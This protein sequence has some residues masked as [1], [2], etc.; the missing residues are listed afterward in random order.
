MKSILF[1]HGRTHRILHSIDYTL[2]VFIDKDITCH[3]DFAID[4]VNQD[5][6]SLSLNNFDEAVMV[7]CSNMVLL[8]GQNLN[9]GFIR[10]VY[11]S[12]KFGGKFYI[13]NVY[14]R[15]PKY[16]N[17]NQER[18]KLVEDIESLRIFKYAGEQQRLDVQRGSMLVFVK[19]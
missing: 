6:S 10:T 18:D 5:F 15:Y 13:S 8:K 16:Q 7:C 17:Y 4:L 11:E 14:Y 3:P 9:I 12:L 2:S 19:I 1:G